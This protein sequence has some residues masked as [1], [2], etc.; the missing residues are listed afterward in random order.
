MAAVTSEKG[1]PG[2][3]DTGFAADTVFRVVEDTFRN[4]AAT[5]IVCDDMGYECAD[6]IVLTDNRISFIHSKSKGSASL[7]AS[8]FQE[9]IGQALKNIGN[10]RY[11]DVADKVDS[12]RGK[13]FQNNTNIDVCRLGDLDT[14][15]EKY[16]KILMAPNGIKP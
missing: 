4:E 8:A 13:Y 9:V 5:H 16:H 12:W 15:E 6:H 2:P 10:M 11:M 3:A 14:F 7:S 1:D